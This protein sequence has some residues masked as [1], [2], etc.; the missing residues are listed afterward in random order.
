MHEGDWKT[1]NVTPEEGYSLQTSKLK[2]ISINATV[3]VSQWMT[4]SH[5]STLYGS[6]NV[7]GQ[8]LTVKDP[9]W[10]WNITVSQVN[11]ANS[12]LVIKNEPDTGVEYTAYAGP[13]P[14]YGW[15]VKVLSVEG[16]EMRVQQLLV[17]DDA[18]HLKGYDSST[19]TTYILNSVD[20]AD[21]QAVLYSGK[22]VDGQALEVT[23]HV[24]SLS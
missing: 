5:F 1:F 17:P 9:I 4:Y 16:G 19:E 13:D 15:K 10:G 14:S 20:L 18:R 21:N 12:T 22:E 24:I 8:F 3:P 23:V 2:N 6:D 11:V 7:P